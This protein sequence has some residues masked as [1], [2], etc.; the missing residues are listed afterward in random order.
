MLRE[1]ASSCLVKTNGELTMKLTNGDRV[2]SSSFREEA[3]GFTHVLAIA[4]DQ[5]VG[6]WVHRLFRPKSARPPTPGSSQRFSFET[7][8]P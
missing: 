3:P 2:V 7:V 5:V 4:L 6:G 1:G 8:R